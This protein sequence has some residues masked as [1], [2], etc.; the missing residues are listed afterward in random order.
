MRGLY[1]QYLAALQEAS[2]NRYVSPMEFAMTYVALDDK[3]Q[4]FAWL[5]KAYE[6]RAPSLVSL[7]SDPAFNPLRSDSRFDDL[8]RRVGLP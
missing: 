8:V 4:A 6:E 2:A 1:S 7:K 3:K 5:E